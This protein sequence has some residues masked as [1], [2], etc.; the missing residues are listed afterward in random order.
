M[1]TGCASSTAA[2]ECGPD[3]DV[4]GELDG[5]LGASSRYEV[6]RQKNKA[7]SQTYQNQEAKAEP[8][9]LPSHV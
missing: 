2:P 3:S 1:A 5:G 8:I 4:L 6:N 7:S 9:L